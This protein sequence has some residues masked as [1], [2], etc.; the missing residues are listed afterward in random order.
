MLAA[1]IIVFRE[2]IEAGLIVGI[3]LAVTQNI[4]SGRL[5]IAAGVAAGLVGSCLVAVFTGT[6][7]A[8]FSG[9][10]QELFNA[11]IL[12]SAALMLIWHNMFMARHG[13][14]LAAEFKAAGEAV[15]SGN[16]SLFALAVV[17]A[18][19]VLREG[20]EVVLFLYGVA[21]S[22]NASWGL[23]LVGGVLGL[24]AGGLISCL[25]YAGLLK[26]PMR[27]LFAVTGVL[28]AFLAAGMAAQSV[29]FLEQAG[30]I[31]VLGQTV[32]NTSDI[33]S[34][35]SMI[36]RVMHTLVG[37][38]DQPSL[39]QLLVYLAILALMF[40]LMRVL[41]PKALKPLASPG[42]R[43]LGAANR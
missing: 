3:G 40:I 9:A 8:A 25:T 13:R 30:L 7:G 36:G 37:Y 35:R 41:A 23:M 27:R 6:I 4:V 34:D 26:I 32:W 29:A 38:N 31:D 16:K 17:V 12:A 11:A 22:D 19:A 28:I 18:V 15:S 33:I 5:W 42:A 10:G 24:L 43:S 20:A 1:A 2:T 21:V 14:E 39:L